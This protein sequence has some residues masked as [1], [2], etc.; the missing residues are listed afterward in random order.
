MGQASVRYWMELA[1][2]L[3]EVQS[4]GV[5]V[6]TTNLGSREIEILFEHPSFGRKKIF[7][8]STKDVEIIR[9][10]FYMARYLP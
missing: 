10:V 8:D 3:R 2:I 6:Y 7:V 9:E 5:K 4:H 1:K